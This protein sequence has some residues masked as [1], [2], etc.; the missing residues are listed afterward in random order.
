MTSQRDKNKHDPPKKVNPQP[1][2]KYPV[3]TLNVLNGI[4]H[5]KSLTESAFLN[6]L[7]SGELD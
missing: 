7:I 1:S 5:T 4:R 2:S 3:P 6:P